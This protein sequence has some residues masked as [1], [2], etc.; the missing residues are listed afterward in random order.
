MFLFQLILV[1]LKSILFYN[2]NQMCR[3][4]ATQIDD[5]AAHVEKVVISLNLAN[6]SGLNM[7]E[8]KLTNK[9]ICEIS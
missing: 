7:S 2:C 6:G 5:R 3:I 1:F 8:Q 4:S 9:N